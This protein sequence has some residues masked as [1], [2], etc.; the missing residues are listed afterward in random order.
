MVTETYDVSY[1]V[2]PAYSRI[3]QIYVLRKQKRR[4]QLAKEIDYK[5]VE[6][7]FV[8]V[9]SHLKRNWSS[10]EEKLTKEGKI[11]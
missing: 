11:L 4:N 3:D 8:F 10:I 9:K 5:V 1:E 7:L 6:D 2:D